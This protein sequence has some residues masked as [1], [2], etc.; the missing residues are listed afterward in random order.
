MDPLDLLFDTYA[1]NKISGVTR[2]SAQRSPTYG[3]DRSIM[4][5]LELRYERLHVVYRRA[6][7]PV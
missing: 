6:L 4:A 2:F 1:V 3:V 7:V 5:T